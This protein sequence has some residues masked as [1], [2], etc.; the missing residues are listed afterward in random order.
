MKR[1]RTLIVGGG[2]SGLA[3]AHALHA[4]GDEDFLLVSD[5]LGGRMLVTENGVNLGAA[6]LTPHY[7]H[8]LK[9]ADLGPIVRMRD[10]YFWDGDG[11]R[12]MLHP[13]SLLHAGELARGYRLVIGFHRRLDRFRRKAG[14]VCQ[15]ALLE[16]DP[17]LAGYVQQAATDLVADHGLWNVTRLFCGPLFHSTLFV[18]WEEANAFYFLAN[19][20]PAFLPTYT[21]DLSRTT[22]RLSRDYSDRV[23]TAKVTEVE[24]MR[25]G[26]AYRVAAAGEEYEAENLVMAIPGRNAA[27]LMALENHTRNVPYCVLNVRGRRRRA[28][29]PGKTV[30]LRREHPIRVLWP[31][32]DGSDILY[33]ADEAPE[34]SSY[35]H[36]GW[37]IVASVA[38]KTAI[39]LSNG[40]WRPLQPEPNLFT[41]GD[42]NIVGLEDSYLTGLFAAN[43]ILGRA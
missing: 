41:V 3:C 43:R 13:R 16:R 26:N 15:K 35:Y 18:P 4:G 34:L 37:K 30:F 29:V 28:Y 6:Y 22:E 40:R 27:E 9:F 23:I 36:D 5:V 19:L 1:V 25:G 10:T 21:A 17:V 8:V 39:Q 11:F 31:Q 24:R 32:A 20:A 12:T 7:R 2:I 33:S 42:H 14:H 38:W